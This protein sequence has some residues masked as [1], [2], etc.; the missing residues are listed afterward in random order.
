VAWKH[1]FP[2]DIITLTVGK[3]K[4]RPEKLGKLF[5][6]IYKNSLQIYNRIIE[7][8]KDID[9]RIKLPPK[10]EIAVELD[11]LHIYAIYRAVFSRFKSHYDIFDKNFKIEYRAYLR[12]MMPEES[13][14]EYEL[15]FYEALSGYMKKHNETLGKVTN[16]ETQIEFGRYIS[17]RV[18]GEKSGDD[19]RYATILYSAFNIDLIELIRI[20][21]TSMEIV[22]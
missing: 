3:D 1:L 2:G 16:P 21:D 7:G 11:Y 20:I 14:L 22:E 17:H 9:S 19:I 15:N 18:I 6:L 8:L 4:I 10:D 5:F 13:A 12:E